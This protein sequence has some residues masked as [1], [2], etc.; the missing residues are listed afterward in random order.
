MIDDD[1]D[2]YAYGYAFY[3]SCGC[4]FK[5]QLYTANDYQLKQW[6]LGFLACMAEIDEFPSFKDALLGFNV[7]CRKLSKL[8]D[9]AEQ[10]INESTTW[11][12]LPSCPIRP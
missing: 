12:R 5:D 1:N 11:L 9:L 6:C 4:D 8:C 10:A 7:D 2:F 3:K